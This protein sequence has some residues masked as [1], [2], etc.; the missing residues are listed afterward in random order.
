MIKKLI[1]E[2][3]ILIEKLELEFQKGLNVITGETGAG[4]SILI[5]AIDL[6]L[7]SSVRSDIAYQKELPVYIQ[8]DF[9]LEKMNPQL[10]NLIEDL[11]LDV[12]D[13][14]LFFVKRI[15]AQGKATSY[16]NGLRVT[17]SVISKFRDI[18][19]DFHNQNDQQQ[20]LKPEYQLDILDSYG[21][22]ISM[23]TEY[24][25]ILETIRAIE[26]EITLLTAEDKANREKAELYQYQIN[27]IE[28]MQLQ[29]GEDEA[30]EK[31]LE[32][33]NHAEEILEYS[34]QLVNEV[35]DSESSIY[36]KLRKYTRGFG[37]FA[38]DNPSIM[39]VHKLLEEC[40]ILLDDLTSSVRMIPQEIARNPKRQTVVETRLNTIND[41]KSKYK[42]NTIRNIL[43][44]YQQ[45]SQEVSFREE[46]NARISAL[47]NNKDRLEKELKT[48]GEKLSVSRQKASNSLSS[49]LEGQ[50][51]KLAMP[52]S[53]F[54]IIIDKKANI[55]STNQLEEND[56]SRNGFDSVRYLFS[57]NKGI[58]PK[59]LKE[60]VS[61]GELSRVM[62]AVKRVLSGYLQNRLIIFD[63]IDAG[64]GGKT[65][66]ILS[67]IIHEMSL[68]HQ[69]MCIT[70]L[71]QIA[72]AGENH[73]LIHKDSSGAKTRTEIYSLNGE[74]RINEIAR[75]L[76]GSDSN[77]ALRHAEE[78]L[79]RKEW[80]QDGN[81]QKT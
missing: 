67:D 21:G 35:Y 53:V 44:Y 69:I 6:V 41:L 25:N 43:D 16:I 65:A 52:A 73:I 2:N 71:S 50:I 4:K 15:T 26:K 48:V 32:L 79:K 59:L 70:H 3:F 63:E 54:Q 30:L 1:L 27:E 77:I 72:S 51:R 5:G 36:D 37:R 19:V 17:N 45:I 39:D 46:N 61:G 57:S 42:V 74:A 12:S 38:E 78:L 60:A 68:K 11:E 18:L 20:L 66:D 33:L 8:A 22:L 24:N 49:E 58:D 81:K 9:S 64:I 7:G 80:S 62:L 13:N 23:R 55:Q 47:K 40:V 10:M 34:S 76:S 75:M 56:Y 29:D 31:E 28:T 14:E